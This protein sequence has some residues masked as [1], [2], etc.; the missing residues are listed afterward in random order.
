MGLQIGLR[1]WIPLA[2]LALVSL[3]S[4]AGCS[5]VAPENVRYLPGRFEFDW[6]PHSAATPGLRRSTD[7]HLSMDTRLLIV[8]LQDIAVTSA[9][10]R[11]NSRPPSSPAALMVV[12][13]KWRKATTQDPLV[14][15]RVDVACNESLK[16]MSLESTDF[17]EIIVTDSRGVVVCQ[18]RMTERYFQG[19]QAWWRECVDTGRL[20]HSRLGYDPTRRSV[21]LSIFAPVLDTS[22]GE[23][24]G[25]A[26]ALL[27]RQL[28]TRVSAPGG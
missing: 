3:A 22:T 6:P 16:R 18:T 8:K 5:S 7:E 15:S 26:R 17:E 1:R 27:R 24:I 28:A 13:E 9:V 21:T 25:V 14:T 2:F 19:D 12:E 10:R 4:L 11:A 23:T 20:S